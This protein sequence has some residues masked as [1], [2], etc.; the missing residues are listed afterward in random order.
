MA[1]GNVL[2]A[3]FLSSSSNQ[4][5]NTVVTYEYDGQIQ[6]GMMLVQGPWNE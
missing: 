5:Q 4:V 2:K 1:G 3:D 6:R